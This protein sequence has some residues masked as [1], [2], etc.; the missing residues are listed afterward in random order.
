[1]YEIGDDRVD[2]ALEMSREWKGSK[3]MKKDTITPAWFDAGHDETYKSWLKRTYKGC[4]LGPE[5]LSQCGR[6]RDQ[7]CD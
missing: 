7:R 1:M 2:D 4:P 5:Q 3:R 6:Q